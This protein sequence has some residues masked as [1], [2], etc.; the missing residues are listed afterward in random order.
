[1]PKPIVAERQ[2]AA[3]AAVIAAT[4]YPHAA[5]ARI[6]LLPDT[7]RPARMSALIEGGS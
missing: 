2:G 1:M 3:A 4:G 5:E 6:Y 7:E